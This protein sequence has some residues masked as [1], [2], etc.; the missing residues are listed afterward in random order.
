MVVEAYVR[1]AVT[2]LRER[3]SKTDDP[4]RGLYVS[5]ADVGALLAPSAPLLQPDRNA[6]TLKRQVEEAADAA[7]SRGCDLRL[8][9]LAKTFL[10]DGLDEELLLV[11]MAPDLDRRFERLYGYLNDDV[12]KRRATFGTAMELVGTSPSLHLARRRL[13][14]E[15]ALIKGGLLVVDEPDSPFLSRALRV[16]DRVTLH[17]LGDDGPDPLIRPLLANA[18]AFDGDPSRLA[19][20][21]MEGVTLTYLRGPHP[22]SA[23][24]FAAAAFQ[25]AGWP[26]LV[27]DLERLGSG[28]LKSIASSV[29]REARLTNAGIVAGPIE[30]LSER[31]PDLVRL[32]AEL[33]SPVALTGTPGWDPVW[34]SQVPLV[35][36]TASPSHKQRMASWRANLDGEIPESD[37][38]TAAVNHLRLGA[39]QIARAVQTARLRAS[40]EGHPLGSKDLFAGAR[41]Q[42]TAGLQRLAERIEPEVGW[43]D[44]VLPADVLRHLH[45]VAGR[46]H[47]RG[48]VLDEWGLRR[49]RSRG[50]GVTILFAGPSGTGKT[51]A[52]EVLAGELGVDLYTVDLATVVDKYVGETEKNLDRIFVEA[53]GVQGILFFDE[54]DALFGKRSEVRDAHDRYSNIEVAYLL[55]RME[56]FDGTAI[57]ATNLR[58]NIDEAFSRRLD[59][60]VTFPIPDEEHR[61]RMWERFLGTDLPRA[62]DVDL[63]FCSQTFELAGGSIRNIVLSAAFIAADNGRRVAMA[64]LIRGTEREYQ[65]LGRLCLESEFGEYFPLLTN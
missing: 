48:R 38:P 55:Q 64:D 3:D 30:R 21:L 13:T 61:Q 15:G 42:D 2:R 23:R 40:F 65:K 26:P 22:G 8:R 6:E 63:K 49:L 57:L 17:L 34:S 58:S 54:A 36:D 9:R 11:A 4:F 19:R 20:A 60:V 27:I 59:A 39:E 16:P 47:L 52:A 12:S 29:L 62:P 46:S 44:L 56:Q 35:V 24:G 41:A 1:A 37:A 31:G 51:M 28:G 18:G 45:E 10:L 43:D 7:E 5:A 32:F 33:P 50:E 25:R 14:A 53:E